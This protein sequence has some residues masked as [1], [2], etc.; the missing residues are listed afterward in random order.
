MACTR[1]LPQQVTALRLQ[2][3]WERSVLAFIFRVTLIALNR[4]CGEGGSY[5]QLLEKKATCVSLL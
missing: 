5:F 4:N 1:A 2:R 3:S